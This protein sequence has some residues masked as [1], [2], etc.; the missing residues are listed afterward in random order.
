M[1]RVHTHWAFCR[2]T[3]IIDR[4]CKSK[5]GFSFITH[6]YYIS[7]TDTGTGSVNWIHPQIPIRL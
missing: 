1:W 5:T 7:I 4:I 3:S 6:Y 2:L